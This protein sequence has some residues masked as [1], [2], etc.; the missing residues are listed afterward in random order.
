MSKKRRLVICF[1]TLQTNFI[2]R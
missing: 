2:W 1:A